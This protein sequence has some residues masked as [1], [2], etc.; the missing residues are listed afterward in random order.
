[1]L[2]R[3]LGLASVVSLAIGT[4]VGPAAPRSTVDFTFTDPAIVES[5]GLVALPGGLFVTVNDSGDSGRVF[6]VDGSGD[7]VGVT[8]WTP[9]PTDVESLAPAG[10]G[11]VWVGDTGDNTGSRSSV[12][13]FQVPVGRGDQT[14]TPTPYSLVYPDGPQDA[15]TLLADPR[16]GRLFVVSKG[17]F[18]GTVYAAPKKLSAEHDNVLR[19]VADS[20]A[21]ATD[22]S[23]YPDG[24]HYVVRNY[25]QAEIY[26]FPGHEQGRLVPAAR[27]AAGRGPRDRPRRVD[28]RQHRGPV[29]R[30]TPGAG[31]GARSAAVVV[32]RVCAAGRV[33]TDPGMVRLRRT[34]PDQPGWSRR[35]A[36]RG[37]V[38]V[39]ESGHR[40]SDEDAQRVRDLVIPPA[41]TDVW[42][43][44]YANG[45]LQAVGTD[46][47]G[48]RQYLYH[49]DWRTRRDAEKFDRMLEFGKALTKAR[50]LVI[51]DLGREGMPLE[52]ACAV[53]VRLLD[54]GYFRIG[55]DVYAD[56]NGSFGLTTLER[57]HV[58]RHQARLVFA[59]VGKSGVEHEIEID[60]AVVIE[61][62]DIMR[63]RRGSDLRLL[64]YKEGRSWRSVLPALVNEYVR[65]STGL[66]ATAKDFRTWHATVLAA[67]ALAE[68]PEPGETKASRKRAVSGAMKEVASF[69]GNT[70]TLARSSYVD[71]RVIEAYEQGR[72]IERTTRR[73]FDTP[74]ERQAALERAT[75]RLIRES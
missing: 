30:R 57:R 4:V 1:M 61:A 32:R 41:W 22:G 62:V 54:L 25:T 36:G 74:D 23:F 33:A 43:T 55:N 75:L 17:I 18:G 48:R 50:E 34:S 72:T 31:A 3:V 64:S 29:H 70:P 73:T 12:S 68:T 2:D 20:I 24:R 6:V 42:V 45:H 10:P 40:L 27:P 44:P 65:A 38:Y 60:D 19:A 7:T 21:I 63:R 47:A 39:D 51:T 53:A 14:V 5:S 49:P 67:A 58:R 11:S 28:A 37:F 9:A 59:F 56:E 8:S 66:E 52:R 35:R 69:L 26:T 16:S 71:P 15:E 13:V 46:D